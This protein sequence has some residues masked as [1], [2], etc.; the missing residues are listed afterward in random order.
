[1]R[2]VVNYRLKIIVCGDHLVIQFQYGHLRV[3]IWRHSSPDIRE[4]VCE[5]NCIA[6]TVK[7][8]DDSDETAHAI[9]NI[10]AR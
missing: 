5:F 6:L 3:D 9:G 4:L 8:R 1:M 10:A 7:Y 2:S